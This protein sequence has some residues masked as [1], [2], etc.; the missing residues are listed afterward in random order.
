[1]SFASLPEGQEKEIALQ[2]AIDAA[3]KKARGWMMSVYNKYS[4]PS[5]GG[6]VMGS[7]WFKKTKVSQVAPLIGDESDKDPEVKK[8]PKEAQPKYERGMKVRDRRRSVSQPQAFGRVEM[9]EGDKMK[10]VW[11]PDSKEN[12]KE[13]IVDMVQDTAI[14]SMIVAEV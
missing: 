11:N 14:L 12:R 8:G 13:E 7:N 9:I 3:T 6:Q 1:M 5:K 2:S 10:I 4:E